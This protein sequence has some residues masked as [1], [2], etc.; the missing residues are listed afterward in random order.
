M[1]SN[2]LKFETIDFFIVIVFLISLRPKLQLI[3]S[4][5]KIYRVFKQVL[6]LKKKKKKKK[7]GRIFR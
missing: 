2:T 7:L 6:I 1:H 5:K 4:I 3:N